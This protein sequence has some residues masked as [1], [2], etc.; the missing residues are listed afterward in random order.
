VTDS[1]HHA[2]VSSVLPSEWKVQELITGFVANGATR[3]EAV[4]HFR[5]MWNDRAPIRFID[6]SAPRDEQPFVK[7]A[8]ALAACHAKW[9][10]RLRLAA[11]DGLVDAIECA[12]ALDELFELATK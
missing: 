12:A 11:K 3:E 2:Y 9:S 1:E 6:G 8:N 10:Q 5:N 7:R 4:Q